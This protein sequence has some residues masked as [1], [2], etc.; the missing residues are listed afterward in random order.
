MATEH[1]QLH[2]ESAV[3]ALGRPERV[4]DGP[5][6]Q[7]IVLASTFHAGGPRAYGR[8]GNDSTAAFEQTLGG[9]EGGR[10]VSFSS[11]MAASSALVEGLPT[12][13]VVVLPATFYNYHRTLFDSQV[14]L[15]RLSL[16]TVDITD[17]AATVAAV[18]GADLLWLEIPT[19]PTLDV[20]DLPALTAAARQHGALS[21]V[22]ATLATPFGIRPLEHGADVVM[23]S[24]TKWIAGHS[25]LVMGVLSTTD[26]ALAGRLTDR[27][28]LTGAI[29]GGL[30]SFLALRGLRT[31]AVRLDRACAN[32]AVLAGRLAEHP[33]VRKLH[34]LGL[35]DHPQ[36][37]RVATLLANHGGLISFTMSSPEL[38][39]RLCARVRLITH[40]TS[41][42]G[43]ESLIERRGRYPGEL[44]QGTPAELVRLSVGIEHVEDLWDDL[45]QALA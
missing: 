39:D 34:Y 9:I 7:P 5:I 22:D 37:D 26:D 38:A 12:G 43:V 45:E 32:A 29:P 20:P 23:H 14:E 4:P 42:G 2:L 24:A 25:D 21:V 33:A 36:A 1:G 16:R 41:L 30:D 31:L 40:A 8:E 3:V 27:R 28:N 19:N 18:G 13:S 15:G 35:A 11:G 10:A 6:N 44:A 17:T